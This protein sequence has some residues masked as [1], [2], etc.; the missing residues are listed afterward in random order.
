MPVVEKK[1][2]HHYGACYCNSDIIPIYKNIHFHK[3][4]FL[5]LK[6]KPVEIMLTIFRCSRGMF[7]VLCPFYLEIHHDVNCI[8]SCSV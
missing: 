3:K 5:M 2:N 8:I 7:Y 4:V 1:N 6:T